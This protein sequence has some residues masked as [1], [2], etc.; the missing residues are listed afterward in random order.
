M[1]VI[2]KAPA[3]KGESGNPFGLPDLCTPSQLAVALGLSAAT[4][5]RLANKGEVPSVRIGHRIFIQASRLQ[6]C[7]GNHE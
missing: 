7:K 1:G 4:V 3:P 5:R 2:V 6:E